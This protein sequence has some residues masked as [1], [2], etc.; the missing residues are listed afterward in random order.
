MSLS[1]AER[2]LAVGEATDIGPQASSRAP[3]EDRFEE[4]NNASSPID[5]FSF[6][7]CGGIAGRQLR[8][9]LGQ[10]IGH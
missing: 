10:L 6:N 4:T 8:P 7:K 5:F 9:L 1:G 3:D 2:G